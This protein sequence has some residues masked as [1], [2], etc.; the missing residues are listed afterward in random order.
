MA[1]RMQQYAD[2]LVA[3]QNKAGTPEFKTVADAYKQLRGQSASAAA[4]AKPANN[5]SFS[6]AF[7]YGIDQPLENMATTA[8]AVGMEGTAQT[9]SDLTDAPEN[10]ESAANR[11]INPEKG[12]TQLF[13]YGIEYLPRAFVEQVGQYGGSL[14]SRAAGGVAGGAL[15]G[16]NPIG[17]AAGAIAGPALFEFVQQLGPVALERAK[18]NGRDE[19][20]WDDW[21]AAAGTAGLSGALNAL[22]VKSKGLLNGVL[23]ESV[24]EAAQS[25]IV[26]TGESLGTEAGLDVNVKEAIGEGIIGGTAAGGV[27]APG[28][29]VRATASATRAA[30]NLVSN[31]ESTPSDFEAAADLARDIQ[32][33]ADDGGYDLEEVNPTADKGAGAV[34]NKVHSQ[35]GEEMKSLARDLRDRLNYKDNDPEAERINKVIAKTALR[36]GKNK[37][38][39]R[40]TPAD[41]KAVRELVGDTAEGRQLITLLRKSN[42][43]TRVHNAGLKGGISQYT[44]QLN[45][46]DPNTGY[47]NARGLVSPLMTAGSLFGAIQT[48]GTSVPLQAAAVVGGRAIDAKTGKRSKIANFVRDY[49]QQQGQQVAPA[50][51]VQQPKIDAQRIAE[52]QQLAEAERK[53]AAKASQQ[54]VA[55]QQG[56]RGDAP[57]PGSPQDIMQIATGLDKSGVAEMMRYIERTN[58]E[59]AIIKAIQ[60]YRVSIDK[61]G[62]IEDK[63]LTPLIREINGLLK[64]NPQLADRR[65]AEPVRG[66]LTET[67]TRKRAGEIA[68]NKT[69]KDLQKAVNED[70]S[71]SIAD[72]ANINQALAAL[73]GKLGPK[74]MEAALDI[75]SETEAKLRRKELAEKYL[76]PYINRIA[77]QQGVKPSANP[78]I[79][80]QVFHG[81]KD[82]FDVFDMAAAEDG[83]HFFTVNKSVAEF[84]G[85][86]K[87]YRVTM[88]NPLE[89]DQIQLEDMV[90]DE[91][92]DSGVIPRD[93]I[94]GLVAQAKADGYDGLV[95]RGFA[96]VDA[97]ADAFLP[98]ASNQIS[99]VK[100]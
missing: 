73:G 54:N 8:R 16:G 88:Q 79:D 35:Y 94:A 21:T 86:V 87:K 91:E 7:Q 76:L 59:P 96:D 62:T 42:E 61:G 40:V 49:A 6:A 11:F 3:N 36:S 71:I 29:A 13:G 1:D 82:N 48:A 43:L 60:E 98:F 32:V 34:V 19:P 51:S 81:T 64:A 77:K 80:V 75:V 18:N 17:I 45:P 78:K 28:A 4:P 30:V 14:A 9:L 22:G 15:S 47:S 97:S 68:N 37:T 39:D 38:K 85:P 100:G 70:G 57:S 66:Q 63:Q 41:F 58:Q 33:V 74:P 10:Y 84:F 24:T 50:P 83:A 26:Q 90:T 99:P 31:K 52:E 56:R 55:R 89:I 23:R 46:F 44:D 69:I 25:G 65:I 27:K 20:T 2:W 67:E 92:S 5:N 12:D 95:I 53:A 72:K 93:K